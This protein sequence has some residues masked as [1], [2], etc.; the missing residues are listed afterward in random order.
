MLVIFFGKYAHII[1]L[2]MFQIVKLLVVDVKKRYTVHEA[3]A[4]P[5]FKREEVSPDLN[6]TRL[7][8]SLHDKVS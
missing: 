8:D 7:I 4:H 5:F 2:G 6:D 3:L 1:F